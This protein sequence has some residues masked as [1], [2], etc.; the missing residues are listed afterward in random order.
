MN[1]NRKKIIGDLKTLL[2]DRQKMAIKPLKSGKEL[3]D[4]NQGDTGEAAAGSYTDIITAQLAKVGVEEIANISEALVRIEDGTYGLCEGCEE[5]IPLPR[6]TAL[7]YATHCIK[8]Q[9]QREN[10]NGHIDWDA[11]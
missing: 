5:E 3:K 4:Q 10:G 8:C 7:L 2:L 1:K 9:R 6:L 11:S